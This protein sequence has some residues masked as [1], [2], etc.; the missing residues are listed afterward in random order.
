[1]ISPKGAALPFTRR[2]STRSANTKIAPNIIV[3]LESA[4]FLRKNARISNTPKAKLAA[5]ETIAIV[6]PFGPRIVV[7]HSL[8]AAR[9]A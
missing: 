7:D 8:E 3:I 1:M 6:H 2:M 5:I 9:A 4:L